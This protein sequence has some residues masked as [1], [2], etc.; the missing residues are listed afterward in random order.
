[1]RGPRLPV[2]LYPGLAAFGL[3]AWTN[4]GVGKRPVTVILVAA[5]AAGM[6]LWDFRRRVVVTF[7]TISVLHPFDIRPTVFSRESLVAVRSALLGNP[8]RDRKYYLVN[9]GGLALARL[10]S[11][12]WD[13]SQLQRLWDTL[14]MTVVPIGDESIR[15]PRYGT[16]GTRQL[17]QAVPNAQWSPHF[18]SSNLAFVLGLL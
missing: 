10:S 2:L 18:A 3:F 5:V 15:W 11:S 17:R 1:M 12:A 4:G 14:G 13:A 6:L 16:V 8:S 9:S 7:T